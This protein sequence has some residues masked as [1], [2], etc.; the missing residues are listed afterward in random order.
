MKKMIENPEID[1][2]GIFVKVK[3]WKLKWNYL[4]NRQTVYSNMAH[5]IF[6][7]DI[8]FHIDQMI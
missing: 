8:I 6:N 2:I 5:I 4:E 7:T 3:L 1:T